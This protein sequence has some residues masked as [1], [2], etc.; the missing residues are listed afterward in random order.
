[1]KLKAPEID[2]RNFRLNKLNSAEFSHLKSLIFWP[3]FAFVFW[4]A[5]TQHVVNYYHP[6]HCALDDYIPFLEIF[7]IPYVFWFV[8]VAGMFVYT[9]L[10][11]LD[12]FYGLMKFTIITYTAALIIFFI[13]PT[14][15][16]LRPVAFERNNILTEL[17]RKFYN[18]DT[19]TNVCPSIHVLGS[20]AVMFSGLHSKKLCHPL[21]KAAFI[22]SGILISIST[23]FMKQ[24]SVL[25]VLAA[26]PICI[27]AYYI[28]YVKNQIS[29]SSST[30]KKQ[31]YAKKLS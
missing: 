11:D 3:V 31:R 19:H 27:I 26:I 30:S 20:M 4:Y 8:Y 13:F 28:C 22:I 1:M 16:Q 29:T 23:V 24:H 5:E 6:M 17:C 14:C 10:Y 9:L 18:F 7:Y 15:Q 12:A 21:W 25:D 2:Y